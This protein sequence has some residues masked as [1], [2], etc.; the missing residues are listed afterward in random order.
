MGF[1]VITSNGEIN[2]DLD[3]IE[4]AIAIAQEGRGSS[5]LH[6]EEVLAI[7]P[8]SESVEAALLAEYGS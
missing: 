8:I 1:I 4:L 2:P 6:G 7:S 5:I 3:S